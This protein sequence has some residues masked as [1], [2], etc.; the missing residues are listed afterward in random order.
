M[1]LLSGQRGGIHTELD[2]YEVFRG[3]AVTRS[4][5]F[6][7]MMQIGA[8]SPNEV[9]AKEG[10]APHPDGDKYFIAS[11]NLSP[12]NRLDEIIDSQ[13]EGKEPVESSSS[14]EDTAIDETEAELNAKVLE[15]FDRRLTK[16]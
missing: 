6:K 13:I 16:N 15:Y 1:K 11:N 9:R 3:D 4:T 5:Y 7:N 14:E 12:L 8:M 2:L 10:F